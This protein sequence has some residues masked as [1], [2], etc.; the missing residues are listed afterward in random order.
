MKRAG[1]T[2]TISISVDASTHAALKRLAKRLHS[3]NVS[4]TIAELAI[5]ARKLEAQHAFIE[6]YEL[7]ELTQEARDRIDAEWVAPPKKKRKRAA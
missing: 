7:P 2:K 4:A 5:D 6:K 1:Q 3:G